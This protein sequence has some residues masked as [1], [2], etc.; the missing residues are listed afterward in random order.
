L[1]GAGQRY[2]VVG[3]GDDCAIYI[4]GILGSRN[5][6]RSFARRFA[7]RRHMRCALVDLRG[8]GESHGFAPPHTVAACAQDVARLGLSPRVVVGHS[9]GGKV[10]LT[11]GA[12]EVWLIDTP[13][14]PRQID[15]EEI[16][17]V[18]AA[19]RAVQL[20]IASRAAL[21][22]ELRARGLSQPIAQWM[23]TNVAADG[24]WKFDL[25]VVEPLLADFAQLDGWP[26]AS[27]ARGRLHV[28]RG[29]RSDRWSKDELLRLEASALDHHVVD[30]AGHWVH[31]EQPEALLRIIAP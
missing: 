30:D 13:L 6:W 23:T 31:T 7:E 15:N 25:D 3:D 9:F 21:V 12:Q 18:I 28:V 11:L 14:G 16:A 17:H 27:S 22:E 29:A 10:A 20:P 8:H 4:H 19:V 1:A 5:N 26:L 24:G 2:D